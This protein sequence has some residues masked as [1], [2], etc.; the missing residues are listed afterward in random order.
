MITMHSVEPMI[1][2]DFRSKEKNLSLT[3]KCQ[4][5]LLQEIIIWKGKY[6]KKYFQEMMERRKSEWRILC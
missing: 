5:L 6:V 1:V 2:T 4:S 3:I